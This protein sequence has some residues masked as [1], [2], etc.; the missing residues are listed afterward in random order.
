MNAQRL[1][2]TQTHTHMHS[3][4]HKRRV[5]ATALS[6]SRCCFS[7]I[8]DILMGFWLPL[9]GKPLAG[10]VR[11]RLGTLH[12]LPSHLRSSSDISAVMWLCRSVYVCV[13]VYVLWC[14]CVCVSRSGPL[15]CGG[16]DDPVSPPHPSTSYPA[17][18]RRSPRRRFP[19]ISERNHRML[20]KSRTYTLD[21][22]LS[23]WPLMIKSAL[24]ERSAQMRACPCFPAPDRWDGEQTRGKL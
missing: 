2:W 6:A 9:K 4:T 15:I 22:K 17:L 13:S 10:R 19:L 23:E 1:W 3:H 24:K 7:L 18:S 8:L 14:I 20:T 16:D 5:S 11:W 12:H 21:L